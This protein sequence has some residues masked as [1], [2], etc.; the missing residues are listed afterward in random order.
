MDVVWNECRRLLGKKIFLLLAPLLIFIG[1]GLI[2]HGAASEWGESAQ[3]AELC[4]RYNAMSHADARQALTDEYEY[5]MVFTT[6]A[7]ALPDNLQESEKQAVV[8]RLLDTCTHPISYEAFTLRYRALYEDE[9]ASSAYWEDIDLLRRQ[10]EYQEQYS[11]F[12]AS[13]EERARGMQTASI[14][15]REGSFAYRNTQ[16]TPEDFQHL[17]GIPLQLGPDAG[18]K[19]LMDAKFTDYFTILIM[20]MVCVFLFSTEKE[21]GMVL[22][23]RTARRGRL[24]FVLAKLAVLVCVSAAISLL[25]Y[26]GN[27]LTVHWTYGF[28]DMNRYVQSISDFRDMTMLMTVAQFLQTF[29]LTKIMAALTVAVVFGLIFILTVNAAAAYAGIIAFVGG[30]MACYQWIAPLSVFNSFKYLNIFTFFDAQRLYA[31]YINLNVGGYAVSRVPV[32]WVFSFVLF[33]VA[34]VSSCLYYASYHT[35]RRTTAVIRVFQK[36]KWGKRKICGSCH[37]F[38]QELYKIL[39]VQKVALVL[40]GAAILCVSRLE[41]GEKL[42][43][44]EDYRYIYYTKQLAGPVSEETE[45][46]VQEELARFEN[47]GVEWEMLSAAVEAGQIDEDEFMRRSYE[48]T[49]FIERRR[50]FGIV[51]EQ[52]EALM[53]V[54]RERDIPV[55]FISIITSDYLFANPQ[56][57]LLDGLLFSVLLIFCLCGIVTYEYRRDMMRL[58]HSTRHGRQKLFAYKCALACGVS[59]VLFVILFA[60]SLFNFSHFYRFQ[61]WGAPI[62][63]IALYSNLNTECSILEFVAI[64]Y[65]TGGLAS[66]AMAVMIALFSKLIRRTTVTIMAS[67]LALSIPFA[68]SLLGIDLIK[69]YTLSGAFNFYENSQHMESLAP[70]LVY[71]VVVFVIGLMCAIFTVRDVKR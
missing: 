44:P 5:G 34:A 36:L 39:I 67:S 2:M 40:I 19:A 33:V 52:H 15:N 45:R 63:S 1:N 56:R 26:G 20:F 28:G 4:K 58:I 62:Q 23:L 6:A 11:D 3:F 55:H 10:M 46:F 61:D 13:M 71:T 59:A 60:T 12:I 31:N 29:L 66:L 50:A 32:T 49:L 37:L 25:Y 57:E 42:Y 68:I 41:W 70:Y 64:R 69:R 54:Y 65:I 7:H 30:S 38:V 53:K 14:F 9:E 24:P 8:Q 43:N 22:L 35:G 51:L 18:V 47:I 48:L 27:I 17:K 16:K 21:N